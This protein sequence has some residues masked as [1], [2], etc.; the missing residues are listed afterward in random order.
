MIS[1]NQREEFAKS[2]LPEC[3]KQ[4]FIASNNL[5]KIEHIS[6]ITDRA[7]HWTVSAA[8]SLIRKLEE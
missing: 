1:K 3:L 2:V 4:S 6:E 7:A 5:G 8:D